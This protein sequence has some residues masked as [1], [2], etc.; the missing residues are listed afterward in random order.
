M[1]LLLLVIAASLETPVLA[2][3]TIT[4]YDNIDCTQSVRLVTP[5]ETGQCQTNTL[6]NYSSF[7]ITNPTPSCNGKCPFAFPQSKLIRNV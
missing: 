1:F 4:T 7:K 3:T 6:G 2:G 5:P